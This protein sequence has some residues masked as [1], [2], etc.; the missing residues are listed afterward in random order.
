VSE[1]T[2]LT[3]Q[4]W[5]PR[6][7]RE[8]D[9]AA[10]EVLIPH[11]VRKLQASY[12]SERQMEAALGTIFAV[13]RQL[14]RDGTYFIVEHETQIVGCGGWSKRLA[15]CG[16]DHDRPE[17][18]PEIDRR[19]DAARIRAFFVHPDWARQGIGRSILKASEQASIAAGFSKAE[20]VATLAGEPLYAACGYS[21]VERYQ[22]EAAG[23]VMLPVVRMTRNLHPNLNL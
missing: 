13:D 12:Y 10:L 8:S 15:V 22:L 11:S 9:I 7:A 16:G 23:V 19:C 5:Q 4:N 17:P 2:Y 6:L 14:I 21:V 1:H 3:R 20:L 18:G